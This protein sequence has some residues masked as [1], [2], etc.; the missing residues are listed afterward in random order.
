M[1]DEKLELNVKKK[2]MI[3]EKSAKMTQRKIL[4]IDEDTGIEIGNQVIEKVVTRKKNQAQEEKGI[5]EKENAIEKEK[6][7]VPGLFLVNV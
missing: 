1:R 3:E 2:L 5:E 4:I 6:E 7:I